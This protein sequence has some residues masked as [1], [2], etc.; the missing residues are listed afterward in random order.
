MNKLSAIEEKILLD[1]AKEMLEM[2][3]IE[4]LSRYTRNIS[5]LEGLPSLIILSGELEKIDASEDWGKIS[6]YYIKM[7]IEIL[8]SRRSNISVAYGLSGIGYS[9]LANYNNYNRYKNLLNN[10]NKSIVYCVSNLSS[11]QYLD[12]VNI[13][14]MSGLSGVGRYLLNFKDNLEILNTIK[15]IIN[16]IVCKLNYTNENGVLVPGWLIKDSKMVAN[17]EFDNYFDLGM[18]HGIAGCLSFLSIALINGISVNGQ[19]ESINNILNFLYKYKME[20]N[21]ATYF[22][23]IIRLEEY[24][25]N[26]INF[27]KKKNLSWCYGMPGIARAVYIAGCALKDNFYKD[28]AVNMILSSYEEGDENMFI[29]PIFCHGLSGYIHILSLFYKDTNIE[30]FNEIIKKSRMELLKFYNDD[31]KFKYLS[32]KNFMKNNDEM[33]NL[34]LSMVDGISSILLTLTQIENDRKSE[35]SGIFLLN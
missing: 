17:K 16:I 30:K 31:I 7:L 26:D 35:W 28:D 12:T 20:Y 8:E 14:C 32:G 3:R 19:K 21:K 6:F 25:N 5:G 27:S 22:P 23:E 15:N 1:T 9:I 34:S 13:D 29:L 24:I 33:N 4:E 18:A 11:N 2:Y 10:I